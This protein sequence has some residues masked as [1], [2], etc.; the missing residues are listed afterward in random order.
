M[1]FRAIEIGG[2]LLVDNGVSVTNVPTVECKV[3]RQSKLL[4]SQLSN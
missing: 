3:S 1:G 4:D 2:K